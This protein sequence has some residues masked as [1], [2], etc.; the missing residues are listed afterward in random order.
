M[1]GLRDDRDGRRRRWPFVVWA[2]VGVVLVCGALVVADL[3]ARAYAEGRIA[4]EIESRLPDGVRGA[5]DVRIGGASVIGQYL[6]GSF[7]RIDID[8]P[9]LTVDGVGAA[10]RVTM[11]GVPTDMAK[12]VRDLSGTVTLDADAVNA[13]VDVPG[14]DGLALGDGVVTLEGSRR[15][16]GVPIDYTATARVTTD[17]SRLLFAPTAVSVASGP[18]G[19]DLGDAVRRI[20]GEDPIPVCVA[21]AL[22]EGVEVADVRIAPGAATLDL[23]AHDLVLSA[24]TL[25]AKGSC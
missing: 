20:L 14:V 12:P 24:R 25:A 17:G 22:P 3:G 6:A 16:L 23:A 11:R 5:V 7:E 2:I 18:A 4:D 1:T 9:R 10:A 15:I 21:G 8:A 13:L 19:L